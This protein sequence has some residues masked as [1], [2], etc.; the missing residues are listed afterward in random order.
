ML[1]RSGNRMCAVR[2]TAPCQRRKHF[3]HQMR[4]RSLRGGRAWKEQPGPFQR[5]FSGVQAGSELNPI[6]LGWIAN[7]TASK[8]GKRRELR[9]VAQVRIRVHEVGQEIASRMNLPYG[10]SVAQNRR[11]GPDPLR[12]IFSPPRKAALLPQARFLVD[13][14]DIEVVLHHRHSAVDF[15]PCHDW[16]SLLRSHPE[17]AYLCT[18]AGSA[19]R[20]SRLV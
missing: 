19:R 5:R 15:S 11:V 13:L 12:E 17:R 1:R 18:S 2:G 20:R 14:Q 6:A 7:R 3:C 9:Q 8:R 10:R 16:R 4:F